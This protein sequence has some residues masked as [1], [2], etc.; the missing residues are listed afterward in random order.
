MIGLA[1]PGIN[2]DTLTQD[3]KSIIKGLYPGADPKCSITGT[4]QVNQGANHNGRCFEVVATKQGD[5]NY[6]V[7]GVSGAY[8]PR[9]SQGESCDFTN[10]NGEMDSSTYQQCVNSPNADHTLKV[11]TNC[12]LAQDQ[13]GQFEIPGVENGTYDLTIQTFRDPSDGTSI[14]FVLEPCYQVRNEG[15]LVNGDKKSVGNVSVTC[16]AGG[17]A[18]TI[19]IE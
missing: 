11:H 16:P 17:N 5:P 8:V 9:N 10:A 19:T 7:A 18:G 4:V 12:T 14:P 13:C 2:L 6:V 15:G 1:V 3:D